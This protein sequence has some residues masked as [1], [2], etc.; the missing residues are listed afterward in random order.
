MEPASWR[1]R[2]FF[3]PIAKCLVCRP[4]GFRFANVVG[5]KQTHGVGYDF[6][7]KL[8]ENPR[9][10]FILG[11]G[12]QNKSY[13]HVDDVLRAL[14]TVLDSNLP[15][16][17]AFNVATGDSITVQQIADLVCSKMKLTN[18]TY[19]YSGGKR[20]WKG[21][22][23][24]DPARIGCHPQAGMEKPVQQPRS[25]LGLARRHAVR[26]SLIYL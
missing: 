11:D 20:G 5:P 26:D 2:P 16:F 10:L 13:L 24:G 18:V 9:E 19:R 14:G 22:V 12:S 7:R 15:G 3:A 4:S 25:H 6:I 21:D 1:A 8:R 17:S 23:P